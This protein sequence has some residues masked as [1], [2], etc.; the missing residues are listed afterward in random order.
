MRRSAVV[1]LQVLSVPGYGGEFGRPVDRFHLKL[2]STAK[3]T[4]GETSSATTTAELERCGTPGIACTSQIAALT[5][6]RTCYVPVWA[7]T[8]VTAGRRSLARISEG[9]FY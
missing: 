4:T 2:G 6:C 1:V 5:R 7:P 9:F 3:L 8:T